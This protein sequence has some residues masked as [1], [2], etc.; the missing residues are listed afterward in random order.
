VLSR[1]EELDLTGLRWFWGPSYRISLADDV[2]SAT[3]TG[4]PATVLT[5]GSPD[6]LR[7]KL[8]EHYA[9]SHAVRDA[10]LHERTST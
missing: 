4:G 2:W 5:A 9:G 6:E 7:T 8:R 3:P 10:D 1:E